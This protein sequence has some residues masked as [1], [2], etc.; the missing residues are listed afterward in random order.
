[1]REGAAL[2]RVASPRSRWLARGAQH[3]AEARGPRPGQH[4]R[5][6]ANERAGRRG[7]AG[8]ITGRHDFLPSCRR[9]PRLTPHA[10]T[11]T[12]IT[13]APARAPRLSLDEWLSFSQ[14]L[15][16]LPKD[17]FDKTINVVRAPLA[18][19]C[20]SARGLRQST[21]LTRAPPPPQY[22]TKVK[23]ERRL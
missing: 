1:M 6:R 22:I 12:H 7:V 8:A 10:R 15:A 13:A 23:A 21:A 4:A 20:R 3:A 5:V 16:R 19:T 14:M 18:G 9:R 2:P 17:M 11:H